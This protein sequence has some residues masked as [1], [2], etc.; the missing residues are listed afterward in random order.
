[1]PTV[2]QAHDTYVDR[3]G[4]IVGRISTGKW[5]SAPHFTRARSEADF[6]WVEETFHDFDVAYWPV[7]AVNS[8]G[9]ACLLCP[10]ISDVDLFSYREGIIDLDAEVSDGAFDF[11]VA[12]QELHGP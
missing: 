8:M 2:Y 12:E 4:R 9:R 6:R 1:M 10:G 11:G 3:A 5:R 7:S